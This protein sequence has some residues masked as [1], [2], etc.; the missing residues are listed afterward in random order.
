MLCRPNFLTCFSPVI[1]SCF[2]TRWL[3]LLNQ[4]DSERCCGSRLATCS[5]NTLNKAMEPYQQLLVP[6]RAVVPRSKYMEA[7]W[8]EGFYGSQPV[9]ANAVV[10]SLNEV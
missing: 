8:S 1:F 2:A 6:V 7:N 5:S 3:W 10:L 9:S 4:A